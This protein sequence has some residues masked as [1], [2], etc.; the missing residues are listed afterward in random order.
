[1][2]LHFDNTP[3]TEVVKHL[4]TLAEVN[5]VVDSAGLEEEGV[6]SS[7]PVTINVDGIKLKSALNLMLEP[8]RLGYLIQN[9]VLNVTSQLKR[10]GEL[11]PVTYPV[12]DLVI[13][14]P[15]FVPAG[16]VGMQS[17]GMATSG[18]STGGFPVR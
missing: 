15:N 16:E 18:T 5:I 1:M 2:S 14:I 3:L 9:D 17:S 13:A 4:S 12:Q 8:L 11:V 10:Q 6:Q 7:T